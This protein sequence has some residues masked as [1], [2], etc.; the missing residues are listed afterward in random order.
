M[1]PQQIKVVVVTQDDGQ[2]ASV[3]EMLE[4]K[5]YQVIRATSVQQ[6]L[7]EASSASAHVFLAD[8]DLGGELNGL[9]LLTQ[10]KDANR[11][12]SMILMGGQPQVDVAIKAMQLGVCDYLTKPVD[13]ERLLRSIELGLARRGMYLTSPE[14]I[15]KIIGSR[16]R[17]I[18]RDCDLTT[19]QLADRVGVTQSQISQIETGRSAASVVTLYRI[20][21]ALDLSLSKLLEGI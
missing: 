6:A 3:T 16:L 9:G 19:Q 7:S 5:G 15:N 1:N 2:M 8:Q 4:S 14:T 17:D 13:G 20:A 18:R 21:H 12:I 10:V 11:Q